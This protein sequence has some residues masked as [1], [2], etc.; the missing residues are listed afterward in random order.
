MAVQNNV[1]HEKK[2]FNIMLGIIIVL[3]LLLL[4][5]GVVIVIFLRQKT[6]EDSDAKTGV[7]G[8]IITQDNAEELDLDEG[9][10]PDG[11]YN[12]SM[13]LDWHFKDGVTEDARIANKETNERTVYFD[14]LTEETE[15][16]VYSSPYIPVGESMQ[17]FTLDKE[18][19]PGTY[20]M[21]VR[22]YLV[23]DDNMEV[24]NVSVGITIY[25]E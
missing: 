1:K 20:D 2:R 4:I 23:D 11:Y 13:S 16:L 17:G 18:L 21:I 14:L 15:E 8:T 9:A 10:V 6:Q 25:V 24:S 3:L 19:N 12:V 5:I 7:K 22:Y